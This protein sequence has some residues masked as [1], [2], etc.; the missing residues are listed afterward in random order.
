MQKHLIKRGEEVNEQTEETLKK[1][2]AH[3]IMG[4]VFLK[5]NIMRVR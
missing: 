1:K 2:V 4:K 5:Y 3:E